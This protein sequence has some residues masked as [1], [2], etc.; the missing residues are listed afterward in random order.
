M[1]KK[2]SNNEIIIYSEYPV[3]YNVYFTIAVFSVLMFIT[4]KSYND[5]FYVVSVIAFVINLLYIYKKISEINKKQKEESFIITDEGIVLS[6]HYALLNKITNH[7]F[8]EWS[9]IENAYVVLNERGEEYERIL[10][11]ETLHGQETHL[12]DTNIVK[13]DIKKYNGQLKRYRETYIRKHGEIKY[14]EEFDDNLS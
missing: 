3:E 7:E 12:I 14:P 8:I 13:K 4:Y 5:E 11:I 6:L 2:N 1:R 9:Q 10:V